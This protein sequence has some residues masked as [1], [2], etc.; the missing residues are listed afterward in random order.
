MRS[1]TGAVSL[2][3]CALLTLS[4]FGCAKAGRETLAYDLR[5]T[6]AEFY[7]CD[8]NS[9]G[10]GD[11]R[12]CEDGES[13]E[14]LYSGMKFDQW[15]SITAEECAAG[16]DSTITLRFDGRLEYVITSADCA[17]WNTL[18]DSTDPDDFEICETE[19]LPWGPYT[20][21][22]FGFCKMPEG[23][24][25]NT[26]ALLREVVDGGLVCVDTAGVQRL[27]DDILDSRGATLSCAGTEL[28]LELKSDEA[29]ESVRSAMGSVEE[30]TRVLPS[31]A[32]VVYNTLPDEQVSIRC[33]TTLYYKI[34]IYSVYSDMCLVT[35][36]TAERRYAYR[37]P[38]FD[39]INALAELCRSQG[40]VR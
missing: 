17:V 28:E 15:A 23:V 20:K 2:V 10:D 7:G 35:I 9:C 19:G 29:L 34:I 21:G 30:W 31:D 6:V 33:S 27:I 14:R 37:T 13:L 24:Y 4:L 1:L 36:N 3:L 18:S 40:R 32:L 22:G 26:A 38:D 5:P 8:T 16:A 25:S 12:R 39:A 11:I